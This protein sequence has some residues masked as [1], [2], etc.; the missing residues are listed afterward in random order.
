MDLF[1]YLLMHTSEATA[2]RSLSKI[3][4]VAFLRLLQPS[5]RSDS[6]EVTMLVRLTDVEFSE[7]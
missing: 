3:N 4:K 1:I 7:M 2:G 6:G 5:L